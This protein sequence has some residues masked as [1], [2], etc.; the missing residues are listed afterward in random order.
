MTIQEAISKL[1]NIRNEIA[2][3]GQGLSTIMRAACF[4]SL[5]TV[6]ERIHAQGKGS[7]GD[8]IGQYNKTTPLYVNPKNSPK[9][10]VP[11]GKNEIKPRR[12]GVFDIE[13]HRRR[14][15]AVKELN[16]ERKTKYFNSYDDFKTEIGRNEIGKVNLF[17][18]G[19]LQ[20][21]LNVI[22]Q[23]QNIGI[24]W[25]DLSF[26]KRAQALELKYG[27]K[28]WALTNDERKLAID[29]GQTALNEFIDAVS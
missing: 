22:A 7:N 25:S 12:V 16:R 5:A 11:Q 9:Q 8:D 4:G 29:A 6:K 10:F 23:G 15:V 1:Q 18:F 24:G 26:F 14:N 2:P 17:L 19:G 28:I 20:N 27:K 3:G 21:Q 13:N